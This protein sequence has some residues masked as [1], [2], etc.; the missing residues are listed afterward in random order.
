MIKKLLKDVIESFSKKSE[1]ECAIDDKK[2]PCETLGEVFYSPESQGTWTKENDAECFANDAKRF[3]SDYIGVPAPI[4]LSD[5]DWFPAPT[6]SEKQLDYMVQETEI[7]RQEREENFSVE[8]DDIHQKMY[9]IATKN[10]STTLHLDP[11]GGS[12]N[13]QSGPG[14]WSSGTGFNQFNV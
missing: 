8:T 2:V 4:Y 5:D 14:G 9:E 7:K 10:Q 1:V 11:P 6:Y 13:F 12:E 3:Y